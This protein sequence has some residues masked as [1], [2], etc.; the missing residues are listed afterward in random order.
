MES[1]WIVGFLSNL[2]LI[3]LLF[4]SFLFFIAEANS[5]NHPRP[6]WIKMAIGCLFFAIAIGLPATI[7]TWEHSIYSN[8]AIGIKNIYNATEKG[9]HKL[10]LAQKQKEIKAIVIVEDLSGSGAENELK[11]RI[12][13]MYN[14]DQSIQAKRNKVLE[15][16]EG[17]KFE[18]RDLEKG[19]KDSSLSFEESLR[20]QTASRQLRLLQ[21]KK[22]YSEQLMVINKQLIAG[23]NELS[24]KMDEAYT[25]LQMI[26]T[27]GQAEA[28]RLMVEIDKVL[29]QYQSYASDRIIDQ[30]RLRLR[31]LKSLWHETRK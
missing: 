17:F 15:S 25:D 27:L 20:D 29:K 24:I 6:P 10:Y 21:R 14:L 30:S 2:V 5:G 11:I 9:Q 31:P 1:N 22:A 4:L 26:E 8:F 16:L 13:D 7:F 3:G 12:R 18:I 19:I 28:E 23:I